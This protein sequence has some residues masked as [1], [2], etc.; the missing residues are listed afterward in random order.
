MGTQPS[1]CCIAGESSI[2]IDKRVA[3]V[4]IL[5]CSQFFASGSA[6]AIDD[7][8]SVLG[9]HPLAESAVGLALLFARLVGAFHVFCP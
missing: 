9:F 3:V 2:A 7:R 4:A 6:S 5:R 1:F 8:S